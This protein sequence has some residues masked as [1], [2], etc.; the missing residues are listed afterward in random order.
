M[1]L[2]IPAKLTEPNFSLAEEAVE[3]SPVPAAPEL[4]A[5]VDAALPNCD[6]PGSL[7]CYL[8]SQ[9]ANNNARRATAATALRSEKQSIFIRFTGSCFLQIWV[10]E[11]SFSRRK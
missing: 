1:T 8:V 3:S 6:P 10:V 5:A 11:T 9:P 2:T 4:S 7:A